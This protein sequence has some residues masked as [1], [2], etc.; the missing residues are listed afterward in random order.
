MFIGRTN[1]EAEAPILW[2]P[3][4]K[5][6]LIWKDPDGGKDWG[7]EEKRTTKDEMIGWHHRSVDMSLGKLQELVMDREAWHVAVHGVSK[8]QTGLSDWMTTTKSFFRVT[9]YLNLPVTWNK[10]ILSCV[11]SQSNFKKII[12]LLQSFMYYFSDSISFSH[13][14]FFHL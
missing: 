14:I 8:S 9:L 13:I 1:V 5:S 12:K 7:Q 11:Y 6:W 4:A 2:P 10:S 3:D